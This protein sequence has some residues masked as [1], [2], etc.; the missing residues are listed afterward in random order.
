MFP[1]HL[2]QKSVNSN[3]SGASS[4]NAAGPGNYRSKKTLSEKR[5]RD[6]HKKSF[7][8]IPFLTSSPE[9]EK[10]PDTP[11]EWIEEI[12]DNSNC[13]NNGGGAGIF[14]LIT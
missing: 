3:H 2:E 6:F 11:E 5:D 10:R 13:T 12:L 9:K 7:T 14:F 4:N 1:G 8:F